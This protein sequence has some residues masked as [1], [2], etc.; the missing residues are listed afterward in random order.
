MYVS[1]SIASRN[2]DIAGVPNG[3]RLAPC[4]ELCI[5]LEES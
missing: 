4:Y 3:S 1:S 5:Q 2:E